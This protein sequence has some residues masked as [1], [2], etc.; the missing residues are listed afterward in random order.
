[1]SA[2]VDGTSPD[3]RIAELVELA[4]QTTSRLQILW[5][6]VG[7]TA[8]EKGRQMEGLING[9]QTIC[10]NKVRRAAPPPSCLVLRVLRIQIASV[11]AH[12]AKPARR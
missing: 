12:T 9:F 2:Y 7:Y 6:E 4:K 3:G 1:M 10:E 5:D 8:Q 11:A